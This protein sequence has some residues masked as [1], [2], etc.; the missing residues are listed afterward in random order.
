[1]ALPEVNL[2]KQN[3][4]KLQEF[5]A[6]LPGVHVYYQPPESVRMVY[7]AIRY[8]RQRV[9]IRSAD[10]VPY[11]KDTAYTVTVIDKD[12]DSAIVDA[13]TNLPKCH[14]DRHYTADNL[15]HDVFTIYL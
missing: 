12:P 5:F 3:R 8:E 11:I 1:M 9:S 14:H 7:P 13:L 6:H 10:N 15:N 4:L 2:T